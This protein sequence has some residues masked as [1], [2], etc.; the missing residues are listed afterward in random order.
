MGA[1]TS[2]AFNRRTPQLPLMLPFEGS[3]LGD[4]GGLEHEF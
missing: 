1:C 3:H 2:S 4:G